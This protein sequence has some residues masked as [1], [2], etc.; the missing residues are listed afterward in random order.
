M[1]HFYHKVMTHIKWDVIISSS[2]RLLLKVWILYR[3]QNRKSYHH[4]GEQLLLYRSYQNTEQKEGC[5]YVILILM[6]RQ[7][8][9]IYLI[10]LYSRERQMPY[11]T[12]R[13]LTWMNRNWRGK[14][15][16]AKHFNNRCGW[17]DWDAVPGKKEYSFVRK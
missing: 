9:P 16:N 1:Q 14:Q 5:S 15:E 4:D 6:Q 12:W 8:I 11:S 3:Y 17:K 2:L 10:K 7:R 13:K